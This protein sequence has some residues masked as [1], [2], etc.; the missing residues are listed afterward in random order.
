MAK[1]PKLP[2]INT[3]RKRL[4]SGEVRVYLYH[5]ATGV[6]LPSRE[7]PGHV[8]AWAAQETL[9]PVDVGNVNALIRDYLLSL[10][11]ERKAASTQKEYK[12]M[13]TELEKR[14]GKLPVKA[15][16]SPK[17]KGVFLDYQ[18]EIGRDRPREADNRLSVLSA[19][20][21]YSKSR[22]K[23]E[24][25][26]LEGFERIYSVDRS[27]IIWTEADIR[28]FMTGATIELQRVLILAI[29]TG[30]RYGDLIR[31]R[32]SDYDGE[33]ISLV[34]S[35][36]KIRVTVPCSA[37]LRTMLDGTPRQCANILT[38]A[39]GRPW[40]T[41]KD[42]KALAKAWRARME[43]AGFYPKPFDELT[44]AEKA[45]YLHFHDMR[46]TAVTLLSEAG[47]TLPQVC[48]V[49]GHTLQSA[50]RILEKYLARTA[51]MSKAA[52]MAFENSPATA[53]ANRLQTGAAPM[54]GGAKKA[55]GEQ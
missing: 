39:D 36:G 50:T 26:P 46:G 11:F 13:L 35:K 52:I 21:S 29:H 32:W 22:G 8:A 53:F 24:S 19:V 49:T 45:T 17:V 18:D 43:A 9:A 15:L 51:A 16:A 34:Q 10:T 14:F 12:R 7:D 20:F 40:F 30:Q 48:A 31:L 23:L 42:D 37:A 28:K 27:E 1:V 41:A 33:A 54:M 5:R 55:Q 25:N 38:R 6:Q 2:R 44:R 4:A 47:A 3:V